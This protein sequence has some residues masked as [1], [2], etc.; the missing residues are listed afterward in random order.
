MKKHAGIV[1]LWIGLIAFSPLGA[2]DKRIDR[3]TPGDTLVLAPFHSIA[4]GIQA[5]V[6]LEQGPLARVVVQGG[7]DAA[8]YLSRVV[9]DGVWQ[10]EFQDKVNMGDS[11]VLHITLPDV[12]M[13]S[14]GG[15][16]SISCASPFILKAPLSVVIGGSGTLVL[17]GTAPGMQVNIAGSGNLD[18]LQFEVSE[19][20]VHLAGSGEAR[21]FVN[22]QLEVSVAGNGH[23]FYKGSPEVKSTVV[24]S[25]F[26]KPIN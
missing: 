2:Q 9:R 19:G 15:S 4:L 25:G 14:I 12:K 17:R 10:I 1:L 11:L 13:V 3:T 24:G 22:K 18:A 16:G 7:G 26:V 21:I 5:A 23:V 6:F 8:G 20:E